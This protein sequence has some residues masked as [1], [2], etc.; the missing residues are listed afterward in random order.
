MSGRDGHMKDRWSR[1]KSGTSDC[2]S[3]WGGVLHLPG[4][5]C[6]VLTPAGTSRGIPG[7]GLFGVAVL[8]SFSK[9]VIGVPSG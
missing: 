3:V 2:G 7:S 5:G 9:P 8:R 4:A 6:G 1:T